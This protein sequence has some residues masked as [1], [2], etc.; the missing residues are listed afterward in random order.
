MVWSHCSQ[1]QGQG[2]VAHNSQEKGSAFRDQWES[3]AGLH[4]LVLDLQVH[5][6]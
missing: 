2:K 1:Y 3:G 6:K 4:D 5:L